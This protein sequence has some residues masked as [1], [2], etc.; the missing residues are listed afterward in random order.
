MVHQAHANG[1]VAV[2]HGLDSVFQQIDHDLFELF[3]IQIEQRKVPH[4]SR[5]LKVIFG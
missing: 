4:P 2:V 1:I 5:P 3:L